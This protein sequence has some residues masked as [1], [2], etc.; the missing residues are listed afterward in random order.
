MLQN[1]IVLSVPIY[2][3]LLSSGSKPLQHLGQEVY[4]GLGLQGGKF[5]AEVGETIQLSQHAICK[6]HT[7]TATESHH[8]YFSKTS[9]LSLTSLD[10]LAHHVFWTED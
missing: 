3:R 7:L 5:K 6:Q 8:H 4:T 9:I 10:P 1:Q 2:H